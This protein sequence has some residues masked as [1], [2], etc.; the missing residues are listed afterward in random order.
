LRSSLEGSLSATGFGPDTIARPGSPAPRPRTGTDRPG[1]GSQRLSVMPADR[2]ERLTPEHRLTT[3][4]QHAAVREQGVALRG[5]H[6]LAL[7][8][9]QPAEPTRFGF[10]ASRRAVG[11]AVQ[12]NRARRRLRE[13]VRRRWPRLSERGYWIEFV[14]FRSVL[15]VPHQDLATE[16]EHLLA[17]AGALDPTRQPGTPRH[18]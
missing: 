9:A 2:R 5:R 7:V 12:R 6:C 18:A 1:G 14:A 8:L 11:G 4:T 10:V 17:R 13:L 15:T 16:V 3:P